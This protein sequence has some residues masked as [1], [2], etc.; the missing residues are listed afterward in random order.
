M[1]PAGV[2]STGGG[3]CQTITEFDSWRKYLLL[4]DIKYR[5]ESTEPDKIRA[6]DFN[7]YRTKLIKKSNISMK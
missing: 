1:A 5:R 6:A 4:F 2:Q 3:F 7:K